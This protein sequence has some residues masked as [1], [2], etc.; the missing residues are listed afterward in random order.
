MRKRGKIRVQVM[1]I[2]SDDEMFLQFYPTHAGD[3]SR[4]SVGKPNFCEPLQSGYQIEGTVSKITKS[5][6]LLKNWRLI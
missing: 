4:I 3:L 5:G 6:V 1:Y 2:N